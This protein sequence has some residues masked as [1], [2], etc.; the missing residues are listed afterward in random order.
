MYTHTHCRNVLVYTH[1]HSRNDV[2]LSQGIAFGMFMKQRERAWEREFLEA[3]FLSLGMAAVSEP[4]ESGNFRLVEC[5][6]V[7]VCVCV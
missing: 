7:C 5:V 2:V 1:I 3:V 4:I 6:C